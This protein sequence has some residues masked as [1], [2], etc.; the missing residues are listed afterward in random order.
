MDALQIQQLK[1]LVEDKKYDRALFY[2][3]KYEALYPKD[4]ELTFLLADVYNKLNN[5]FEAERYYKK[6]IQL[7]PS[8][9]IAYTELETILRE[10]GRFKE[11]KEILEMVRKI[12]PSLDLVVKTSEAMFLLSE[13]NLAKG[14]KEYENRFDFSH[15]KAA[16][17]KEIFPRWRHQSLKGKSIFMR[18]EQGLGDTV[19]FVRYA[20]ILK[21]KG[22]SRIGVM[23][24]K[25]LHKL[26][27]SVPGV[28]EAFEA[29]AD[30]GH[31]DYEVMMMSMPALLKTS[32]DSDIPNKPYFKVRPED[33][34]VWLKKMQPTG[35]LRVGLVWSGELKK[36][37]NDFRMERMNLHRSIPIEKWRAI[38]DVDCDF[39]SLQ[40]GE[41]EKDL[42]D[43][44]AA[45]PIKNIMGEVQ[46]FYDTACIIDNLDLVIAVDTSTAH[47]AGA[48]GK[49][50]W[51]LHRLD[52][53]WRWM[54]GRDDSPWY[55]ST[56]IFRQTQF[57]EWMP[58]IGAISE[59][60]KEEVKQYELSQTMLFCTYKD[61]FYPE[62]KIKRWVNFYTK[63]GVD[64]F[65]FNDGPVVA[66]PGVKEVIGFEQTLGR[67]NMK[68]FPGWFRSFLSSVKVA[69]AGGYKKIIHCELD[70]FVVS[71]LLQNKML[72]EWSKGWHCL[73]SKKHNFP[74]A[75]IQVINVDQF[76]TMLEKYEESEKKNWKPAGKSRSLPP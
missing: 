18:Y 69:K 62:D 52:G 25:T 71:P 68:D 37:F 40:K 27:L 6:T 23:C 65:V 26:V 67:K 3:H 8:H 30:Y 24:K 73:W 60:L 21:Q 66:V 10:Q 55:P 34:Q 44:S 48:L 5:F 59:R 35:R 1:T 72:N 70:A 4:K 29:G 32:K 20:T 61:N 17:E 45:H 58:I 51:M 2:L 28:D 46:D 9:L 31:F 53:D 15:M 56:T 33:S 54:L 75:A 64:L 57:E 11:C 16:Y 74:E 49:K 14:F 39:Y 42:A 47:V 41:R 43:F 50:T 7:F 63:F 19:Q 76:P 36:G 38:L 22:A 13:G 12:A